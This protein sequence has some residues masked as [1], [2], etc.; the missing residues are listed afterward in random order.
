MIIPIKQSQSQGKLV[1]FPT[2]SLK[3]KYCL[4]PFIS[5][6]IGLRGEVALCGCS[7]WHPSI[8]GNIM[9]NTLEEILSNHFSQKIRT[10]IA[11]GS[12]RYCNEKTCGVMHQD[13]LIGSDVLSPDIKDLINNTDRYKLPNEI[14][15]ALD[16]TCNLSCPS[17]RTTVI[18]SSDHLLQ[19]QRALGEKISSNIFSQRSDDPITVHAST[20]GELFASPLLLEFV[21]TI[22]VNR[23]PNVCLGI[24]TN[25]LLAPSRW[26]RLGEMQH[27]VRKI[28]V[29]VD[30]AFEH[31]YELLRRGGRWQDITESL[32]WISQH[33]SL[34]NIEF[35]TRM[36]VQAM[37]FQEMEKFY[38]MC[39]KLKASTIEF[40][41]ITDWGHY[42][43]RFLEQD[44][45]DS[46]H[47]QYDQ[48]MIE[49]SKICYLPKTMISGGLPYRL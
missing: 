34:Y 36:V 33:S 45:F 40:T 16:R 41:R 3:G 13:S 47:E 42:G 18:K 27:R 11:D 43:N 22:P 21:N 37:N 30:A 6:T 4:A 20:T 29:T 2:K 9:D 28:T 14:T 5:V 49:L 10:S 32:Q 17:C 48:A 35:R 46:R 39:D 12:Y 7:N 25:G 38:D 19:Y 15:V 23:Y 31:T 24:Q 8:V 1:E 44:V 26:N